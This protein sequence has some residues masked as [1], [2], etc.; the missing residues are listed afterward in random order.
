[1]EAFTT[2]GKVTFLGEHSVLRG[3]KALA[4]PVPSFFLQFRHFEGP[5]KFEYEILGEDRSIYDM[6]FLGALEKALKKV[7][8]NLGD[9]TGRVQILSS[10]PVSR[11][12]GSSAA[13]SVSLAKFF[14]A[15]GYL[16]SK[17][18][19]SFAKDM[20]SFFHGQS[21][22]LDIATVLSSDMLLFQSNQAQ[23]IS[24]PFKP[25]FYLTYT[26][27]TSSTSVCVERVLKFQKSNFE[28]AAE[29][30]EKMNQ[31]VER[32]LAAWQSENLPLLS[33]ALRQAY[34]VFE[35]WGLV[36]P[37]VEATI[38]SLMSEGALAAK[39]VGSGAGGY[40][41]SLWEAPPQEKPFPLIPL[42]AS[43]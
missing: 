30:D 34:E 24:F 41:L 7:G 13:L 3:F 42:F 39:P 27:V 16:D 32:A 31:S 17:Y 4:L 35:A 26:G 2:S 14:I 38:K 33:E 23:P 1:M 9:L 25:C 15:K 28:R 6:I 37:N 12:L 20:E 22:G 19:Y 5:Q 43:P 21:S 36:N 10:L 29:L 11:G 18:L 8:K 40:V